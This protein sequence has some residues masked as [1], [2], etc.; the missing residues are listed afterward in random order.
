MR[1]NGLLSVSSSAL[2][3]IAFLLFLGFPSRVQP[4][5]HR[6]AVLTPGLTF[7]PVFRGFQDGLARLGYTQ[8]KNIAFVMEDTKGSTKHLVARAEKLLASKPDVL[9]AVTTVHAIAAHRATSV[10]PIVF[11]WVGDPIQAGPGVGGCGGWW[12]RWGRGTCRFCGNG[13]RAGCGVGFD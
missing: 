13:R 9:F 8:G 10:V 1:K 11:G 2:L 5:E 4:A 3:T 7:D 6:I 12:F